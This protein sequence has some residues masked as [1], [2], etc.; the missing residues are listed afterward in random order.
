MASGHFNGTEDAAGSE[1]R[2]ERISNAAELHR[3]GAL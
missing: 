1:L 2:N 3:R